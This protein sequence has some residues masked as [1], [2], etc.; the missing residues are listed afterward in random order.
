MTLY[1]AVTNT[2][3]RSLST[4][5]A[6]FELQHINKVNRA[7]Q[8]P[9]TNRNNN[10]NPPSDEE[11]RQALRNT[12]LT[13]PET[14]RIKL[15]FPLMF[16]YCGIVRY[17]QLTWFMSHLT[18][19]PRVLQNPQFSNA[20][21]TSA[22]QVSF[23]LLGGEY[24]KQSANPLNPHHPRGMDWSTPLQYSPLPDGSMTKQHSSC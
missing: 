14:N 4:H 19:Y 12:R 9:P 18:N 15:N 24:S 7:S 1:N 21:P 13:I 3:K 10:T 8:S 2:T 5:P 17:F 6:A 20:D 11:C 22:Q 16:L 23:G